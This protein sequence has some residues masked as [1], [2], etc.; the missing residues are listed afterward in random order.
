MYKCSVFI[1]SL[2]VGEKKKEGP[3]EIWTRI[4]RFRVSG[5]NRYT[6]GPHVLWIPLINILYA[7]CHS[8]LTF[9]DAY[10]SYVIPKAEYDASTSSYYLS[11]TVCVDIP[12]PTSIEVNVLTESVLN[13]GKTIQK[14]SCSLQLRAGLKDY[15][16]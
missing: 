4:L 9:T 14:V 3:A 16:A 10:V 8:I 6:T 15:V 2:L 5:A 1:V 7:S 11:V 12:K 13:G